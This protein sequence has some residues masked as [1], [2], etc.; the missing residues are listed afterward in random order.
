MPSRVTT[1]AALEAPA[2]YP[3]LVELRVIDARLTKRLAELDARV[4]AALSSLGSRGEDDVTAVDVLCAAIGEV[5]EL[6]DAARRDV[7]RERAA[8]DARRSGVRRWG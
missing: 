1:P 4:D 2:I 8:R 3:G 5:S 6:R 7:S